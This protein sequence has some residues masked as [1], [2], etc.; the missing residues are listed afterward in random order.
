MM[1]SFIYVFLTVPSPSM[2]IYIVR[3]RV[4]LTSMCLPV[5]V[6]TEQQ[7]TNNNKHKQ[8][9]ATVRTGQR[10][11][12]AVESGGGGDGGGADMEYEAEFV[13]GVMVRHDPSH[14]RLA[15]L[16]FVCCVCV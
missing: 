7:T 11:P 2:P 15:A 10:R 1:N 3:V 8:P 9:G 13:C 4:V 5:S 6:L 14:L 12:P 16:R